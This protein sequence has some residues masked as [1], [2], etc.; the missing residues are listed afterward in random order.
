MEQRLQFSQ[1]RRG[2]KPGAIV[3]R[4]ERKWSRGNQ[5]DFVTFVL[6]LLQLNAGV[7]LQEKR[8]PFANYLLCVL[9]A[10]SK[11]KAAHEFWTVIVDRC[12]RAKRI[13]RI[14][15]LNLPQGFG[16]RISFRNFRERFA[17]KIL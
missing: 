5:F 3:C 6:K 1:S 7:F 11:T 13:F 4:R 10:P 8:A 15:P 14:K 16:S 2:K 9:W 12:Q 17:K